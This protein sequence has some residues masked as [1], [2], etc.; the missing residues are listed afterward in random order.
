MTNFKIAEPQTIDQVTSLTIER[1]DRYSLMAGG[2]DLLAEIK[3]EI[4]GP[5]V[6][7]TLNLFLIFHTLKRKRTE[8]ESEL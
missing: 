2:T 5:E 8:S 4:I 3:D 7:W 6:V 1:K